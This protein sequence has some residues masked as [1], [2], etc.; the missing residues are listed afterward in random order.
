MART[1]DD[2][3]VID[4]ADRL[5]S[6]ELTRE[7]IDP[8]STAHPSMTPADA[9]AVQQVI[10]RRCVDAGSRVLGWKLGLT[11]AA[12]QAQLGV[13]QPDFGPILSDRVVP[14][15]GEV[16]ATELIRPRIEAEIA[17]VLGADLSGPG[18]TAADVRAA[19]EAV[20]P[21]LEVIDSRIRDWRIGLADTIADLA[22]TA[23]VIVGTTRTPLDAG[24]EPRDLRA[25]LERDGD[26]VGE[27][28]G[29]A[30]LGDPLEAVAWAANTLG[31]L[32]ITLE[33]GHV[34]MTGALHASVPIQS[35]E[36]YR[37]AIDRLGTASV[38]IS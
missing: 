2:D 27:G 13:D 24:L 35:G 6:A 38:R 16:R 25:I 20:A 17:F 28:L 11:S 7:P 31:A 5:G 1:L 19:T 23:R 32:G 8:I 22:S 12:M 30:A 36:T 9:Y 10:T 4:L 21:A 34:I 26:V 14:D 37:T 33:A 18:V 3:T 29:A 15:G